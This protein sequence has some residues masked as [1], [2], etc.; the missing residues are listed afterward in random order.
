MTPTDDDTLTLERLQAYAESRADSLKMFPWCNS[1]PIA[2]WDEDDLVEWVTG[3]GMW[4]RRALALRAALASPAKDVLWKD[5]ADRIYAA[6]VA[7]VAAAERGSRK[8]MAVAHPEWLAAL[9][10]F[11]ALTSPKPAPPDGLDEMRRRWHRC[12]EQSDRYLAQLQAL[13]V[14]PDDNCRETPPKTPSDA[15]PAPATAHPFGCQCGCT[16]TPPAP[17]DLVARLSKRAEECDAAAN[18]YDDTGN[19]SLATLKRED[20]SLFRDAYRALTAPTPP[21]E[22]TR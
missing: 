20:A 21:Q 5:A 7:H 2:G 22:P 9:D 13:G 16:F 18:H 1:T 15:P 3:L 4:G 6:V 19:P 10:A 11:A 14:V 8:E 17:V 12:A